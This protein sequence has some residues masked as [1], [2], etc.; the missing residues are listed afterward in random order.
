MY[1]WVLLTGG[2]ALG[3]LV[4]LGETTHVRA[5]LTGPPPG[6]LAGLGLSDQAPSGGVF[7]MDLALW[8]F[9]AVAAAVLLLG[10]VRSRVRGAAFRPDP[11]AAADRTSSTGD[12][13]R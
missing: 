3:G 4:W 6:D 5:V 13:G 8:G 12:A 11:D 1:R 7:P 10:T 2:A 9:L